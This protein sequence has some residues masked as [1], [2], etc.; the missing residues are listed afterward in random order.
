MSG[1][2]TGKVWDMR[3]GNGPKKVVLLA[4]ADHADHEGNNMYPS[5]DLIVYKTELSESTVH[6]CVKEL[7]DDGLLIPDGKG[8]H[9]TNK[10]S[11]GCQSDTLSQRHSVTAREAGVS[12]TKT[13]YQKQERA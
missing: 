1:K 11:M 2:A 4:Y 3:L 8:P 5:I 7:I 10:Y 13:S 9:N 12:K 6:R